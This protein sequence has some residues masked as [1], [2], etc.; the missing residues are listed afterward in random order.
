M[1]TKFEDIRDDWKLVKNACRTTMRKAFTEK[2][3]T[4]TFK[5]AMLICE[6]SPIRLI[7]FYWKWPDIKYWLSTEWCRHK[8][9]KFV[10]SQRNDRQS[11]YD[12]NAA[13]QDALVD[14]DGFANMQQL[15]DA[16]RKRLC[17]Q[18][19]P[20][21]RELAE[22]FKVKLSETNPAESDVLVPN[23]IYRCGCPEFQTCGMFHR[24][25]TW[26]IKAHPDADIFDL[27]QRYDMYNEWFHK[28]QAPHN[29][30]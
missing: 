19:H 14:H 9:E 5:K 28:Y 11:E 2:D 7:E 26:A 3:A 13:R 20:E 25:W 15:I 17:Y 16:F 8:H 24:F 4:E 1:K 23:C 10:S 21:A 12:R 27:Q 6:H 22:D 30:D 18:A 29:D